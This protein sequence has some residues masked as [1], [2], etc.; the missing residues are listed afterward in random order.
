MN[1]IYRHWKG[2]NYVVLFVGR[3]SNNDSNREEVVI[4]LSLGAEFAGRIN[5]RKVS[6]FL[7]EI[8]LP[9]GGYVPRFTYVGPA[10]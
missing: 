7:E 2:S 3:D 9:D 1:G 5:V 4:Y 6:E 8:T 10:P